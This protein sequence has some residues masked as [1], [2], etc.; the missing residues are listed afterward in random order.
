MHLF[1]ILQSRQTKYGIN[2]TL[3][4]VLVIGIAIVVNLI[5]LKRFDL[6][7]D[8][9]A[10]KWYT[11][12][13]QTQKVLD[14]LSTGIN[15]T[16]FF[17]RNP[18]SEREK[19]DYDRAKELLKMYRRSSDKIKV[20]F[21][22]TFVDVQKRELYQIRNNGTIAFETDTKFPVIISTGH[23]QLPRALLYSQQVIPDGLWS[24]H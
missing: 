16:A 12:S 14:N 15:I 19:R 3:S 4:I 1:E 20:T 7:N 10:E 17:S 11:L 21:V 9:T 5:V 6:A 22:D 23:S 2:V 18:A 24:F 13:P 8:L